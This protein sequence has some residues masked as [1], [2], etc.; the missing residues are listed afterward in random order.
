MAVLLTP[1]WSRAESVDVSPTVAGYGVDGGAENGWVMDGVFDSIQVNDQVVIRKYRSLDFTKYME[2]R[3]VYEFKLPEVLTAEGVVLES[4]VLL[5]T[6][7]RTGRFPSYSS[8]A[9]NMAATLSTGE[10]GSIGIKTE[11]LQTRNCS[12]AAV[13][14]AP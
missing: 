2:T 3:G 4:A 7:A 9:F 6:C 10:S 12:T 5:R 13:P 11:P 8:R 14:P 1:F